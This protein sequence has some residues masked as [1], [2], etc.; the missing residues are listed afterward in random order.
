[1]SAIDRL[2][3]EL[4]SQGRKALMPFVT[5]GDPDLEFT[6]DVLRELARRGCQLCEL[7]IPYSDP[8]ADGPVIQASYTRALARHVKLAGIFETLGRLDAA[9][10]HAGG[11]HGQLRDRLSA[12]AGG[13][14]RRRQG[15]G[16]GRGD[17]ARPAGGRVGG[18]GRDLPPRG[19]QPDPT[20]HADDAARAGGADR[21]AFDRL[22]LLRLRRRDHGRAPR[23]AAGAGR[24]RGLAPT[25]TELPICIGF[26]IS[27]PEH[28]RALAPVADGLIVGSAFV[29][30]LAEADTSSAAGS[31]P[32]GGRFRRR[33]AGGAD[34]IGRSMPHVLVLC[35]YGSLNGGERSLLAV[36]GGLRAAGYR[37][38]RRGADRG[39][40]AAAFAERGVPVVGLDLHDTQGRR[41]E[42]S[43][44]RE[45]IRADGGGQARL[46][47]C[48]QSVDEPAVRP[49]GR[50]AWA[51]ESRP[52]AGH[53][54]GP[55]GGHRGPE[56]A[57]AAGGRVARDARLV[58]RR[59][60]GPGAR[61]TC[62]TTASI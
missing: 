50:A 13:V 20:G 28:V 40:L 49:R 3:Q 34:R 24:Q 51:A 23:I 10:P 56:S 29:R 57:H 61:R 16:S 48:Q 17:R 58:R 2:F 42:L 19:F 18:A 11:H 43:V 55:G 22:S 14:R 62:C 39:P 4:R 26:G 8:I 5:A 1:M 36:L 7:G 35:E 6:A 44:C 45:R 41:F 25:Q 52:P 59:G 47:S 9:D 21:R 53:H 27:R 12:R 15:G 33:A 32:R 54:Q 38:H 60:T 31:A 30:R 37:M 46:D